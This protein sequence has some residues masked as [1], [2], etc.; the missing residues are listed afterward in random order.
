MAKVNE[1]NCHMNFVVFPIVNIPP[2]RG[3]VND[4]EDYKRKPMFLTS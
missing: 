4:R 1:K 3:Y 2:Y